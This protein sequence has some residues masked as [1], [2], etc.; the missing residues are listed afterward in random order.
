MIRV[1]SKEIAEEL[2][3]K[4]NEHIPKEDKKKVD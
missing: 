1:S 2:Y 4:I 3:A